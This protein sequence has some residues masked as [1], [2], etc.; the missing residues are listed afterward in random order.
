[1]LIPGGLGTSFKMNGQVMNGEIKVAAGHDRRYAWAL[2]CLL[3]AAVCKL[4]ILPL[5]SS[6]WVDEMVTAFVVHYGS[7]HPTLAVAPQVTA[8]VYYWLPW[9]AE[10]LFG[11]SEVVY[12]IP[13]TL[14]MGLSLVLLA[15]LA[16]RLIHPA[17]GWFVVFAALTLNGMNYEAA[18]A[19]PY[20]MA[21]CV[22]IAAAWFLVRWLDTARW[23][24]ASFFVLCGALLWRVHLIEWPFYAVLGAYTLVRVVRGETPVRGWRVAIVYAVLIAA[25]AP[26]AVTT[27]HLLAET[28]A[29]VIFE[30]PPTWRD[31]RGAFKLLLVA[32]VGAGAWLLRLKFKWNTPQAPSLS[33]LVL[34]A[35]WWV[36]QPVALFTFSRLTG[37][38]VFVPRYLWLSLPGAALAA[39]AAAAYFLPADAWKPSAV[40]IGAIALLFT[41]GVRGSHRCITIRIGATRRGRFAIREFRAIRRCCIRVL[42]LRRGVRYGDPTIR[43]PVFCTVICS[44][45]RS[46]AGLIFCPSRWPSTQSSRRRNSTRPAS[47]E[48]CW[49]RLRNL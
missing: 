4:W 47:R 14:L 34:I 18:D 41:G 46:A 9:A 1:M 45:T 33:A 16:M 5:P 20:A 2:G 15:R 44:R 27:L 29:H 39:T 48:A 24:E 21:T 10:R 26:V 8:T 31:F 30:N 37:N 40:A 23:L 12:R 35:G 11:F 32:G 22:A 19:R 42:S 28:K 43:F 25:L 13:S 36:T 17:A 7:A 6:F 3:A 38:N 49:R